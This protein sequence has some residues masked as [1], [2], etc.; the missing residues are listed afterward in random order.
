[1][2]RVLSCSLREQ[3]RAVNTPEEINL[4]LLYHLELEPHLNQRSLAARLGLSLGK[5]NYCLRALVGKGLI[6][7]SNFK[8]NDN[9]LTYAYLL[10]P[11][12]LQE[13]ARLTINFLKRKQEEYERLQ[14]EI[15]R[16]QVE[17]DKLGP[18]RSAHAIPDANRHAS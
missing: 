3:T 18:E 13:K 7:I 6:K 11:A 5:A 15:A 17:V 2:Y 12:G 1:M 14:I 8:R 9:K 10:T 16:L 4:R